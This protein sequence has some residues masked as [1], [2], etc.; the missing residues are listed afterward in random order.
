MTS[1]IDH[2]RDDLSVKESTRQAA[3]LAAMRRMI[4][5][6][7]ECFSL[8]VA[9]CNSPALREFLISRLKETFPRIAV[10]EVPRDTTDVFGYVKDRKVGD[11]AAALFLTNLEASISTKEQDQPTLRSLNASRELWERASRCPIVIWVPEWAATALSRHAKDLWRYRSHRFEFVSEQ[12]SADAA[13]SDAFSGD[14]AGASNLSLEEKQFRLAEL[15]Q[16]LADWGDDLSSDLL[17]HALTWLNEAA[18]LHHVTGDLDGAEAMT[19]KS[20]QIDEKLGRLKGMATDYG[21]LGI[22]LKT[23]GDLGGAEAMH[24]KS[25]E[26]NEKLGRLEGM[27]RNYGNLGNVLLTRGDID[28]AESMCRKALEID[29]KL[30]RLEGVAR[31]YG[32]LGIV[33]KRRG[34][35]DGADAMYRRSLEINEKL[36]RLAGVASQY[37]NLGVVLKARGDLDGAEAMYRKSLNVAEKLGQ[38]AS[39]AIQ[40]GNLADVLLARGDLDGAEAMCRKSLEIA[41]KFGDVEGMANDYGNLGMVMQSRGDLNGAREHWAKALDLYQRIGMPDSV[42]RVREWLDAIGDIRTEDAGSES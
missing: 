27:A 36:G 3:E 4:L 13:V 29:E 31:Q 6:S 8:S 42:E 34:D 35:L 9:V 16:R 40:Y 33:L 26:I 32:N 14:V 5:A 23:R 30:G 21:N 37:G 28:G 12:A 24:R 39:M 17:P 19:R 41:E 1:E 2:Q 11:D 20:L 25:L 10:V 38:L 15:G 22:V 18:F 7:S